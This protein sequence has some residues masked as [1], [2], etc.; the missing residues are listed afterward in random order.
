MYKFA[1][2]LWERRGVCNLKGANVLEFLKLLPVIFLVFGCAAP[3]EEQP[4]TEDAGMAENTGLVTREP[5]T[6]GASEYAQYIGQAPS[7]LDE[8]TIERK[9]R[10]NVFG[11][12]MTQEYDAFRINFDLGEDGAIAKVS[13]G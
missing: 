11:G 12:I 2:T 6:C 5:D 1:R 13:C 8:L 3:I 9:Y 4:V 10:I 7:V